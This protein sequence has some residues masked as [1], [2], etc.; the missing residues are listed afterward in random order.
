MSLH[1]DLDNHASQL[2][3]NN[4]AYRDQRAWLDHLDGWEHQ[5][6]DEFTRLDADE[7]SNR[8]SLSS[9]RGPIK[10]CTTWPE[11]I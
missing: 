8:S 1:G 9:Y 5:L 7:V 11:L 6:E 2:N 3:P 4:D 10:A